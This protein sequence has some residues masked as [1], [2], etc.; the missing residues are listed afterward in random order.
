M[1]AQ[2]LRIGFQPKTVQPEEC[3]RHRQPGALVPVHERVVPRQ[4]EEIGGRHLGKAAVEVL[5]AEG[6]PRRRQGRLE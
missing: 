2:F 1:I 4:V 5:A 6:C 3:D